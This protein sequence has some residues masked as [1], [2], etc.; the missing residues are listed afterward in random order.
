[1][2][3]ELHEKWR[4]WFIFNVQ[5]ICM[6]NSNCNLVW[7]KKNEQKRN[8]KFQIEFQRLTDSYCDDWQNEIETIEKWRKK[9]IN[10]KMD[11]NRWNETNVELLNTLK[12]CNARLLTIIGLK[13]KK[14]VK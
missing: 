8:W 7:T 2:A 6:I 13:A 12:V 10:M 4:H 5:F 14:N 1:M 3:G 9:Y 11:V